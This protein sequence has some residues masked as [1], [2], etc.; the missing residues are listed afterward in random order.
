MNMDGPPV[1]QGLA[2][3]DSRLLGVEAL[4]HPNLTALLRAAAPRYVAGTTP[5]SLQ[6]HL[7]GGGKVWK[8][9]DDTA[10]LPAW[11]KTLTH[12][13]TYRQRDEP[14]AD[15]LRTLAPDLGAYAN[16]VWI[17]ILHSPSL[18]QLIRCV[19]LRLGNGLEEVLVG[20]ELRQAFGAQ[21]QVG[22]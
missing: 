9:E 20:L 8:P 1:P 22:P 17:D 16:E 3:L 2:P 13:I 4:K 11:R 21:D 6:G 18:N 10:V 12:V 7:I 14:G 5:G 19:G 15:S